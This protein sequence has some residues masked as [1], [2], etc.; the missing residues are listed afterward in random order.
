MANNFSQAGT[1]DVLK[2]LL[3][4]LKVLLE[5]TGSLMKLEMK[6]KI[7]EVRKGFLNLLIGGMLAYI[8]MWVAIGT[9]IF[10]IALFVPLWV[11]AGIVT[12]VVLGGGALFLYKGIQTFKDLDP[13]PERTL[14]T[15]K[16]I[17]HVLTRPF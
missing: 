4:E 5:E 14:Q 9:L 1:F 13:K 3:R 7:R 17:N 15:L 11:A 6:G 2:I 8:G 16:E 12:V 10:V